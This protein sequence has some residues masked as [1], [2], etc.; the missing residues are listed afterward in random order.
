MNKAIL[1]A[2]FIFLQGCSTVQPTNKALFTTST[3]L[4]AVDWAQT[5]YIASHPEEFHEKNPLLGRHPSVNK[6]DAYF[7]GV[8][9]ANL[10]LYNVLPEKYQKYWFTGLS[11]VEVGAIGNN[12]LIGVGF[13]W[14]F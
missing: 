8:M 4:L 5:R 3:V 14:G 13:D 1:L 2:L 6:V 10:L 11:I 7:A 12:L 9:A